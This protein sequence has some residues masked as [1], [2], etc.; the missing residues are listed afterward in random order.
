MHWRSS[1]RRPRSGHRRRA[2]AP[3]SYGPGQRAAQ[4]NPRDAARGTGTGAGPPA[5]AC[6]YT[7]QPGDT[8]WQIATDNLGDGARFTEIAELNY[9]V[10]QRDGNALTAAR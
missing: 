7:V 1:V 2:A 10:S 3:S 9:G 6:T 8:L 4:H 5:S